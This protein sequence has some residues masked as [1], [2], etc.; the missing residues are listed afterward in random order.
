MCC[1]NCRH[2]DW[3]RDFCK[4]WKCKI[5]YRATYNCFSPRPVPEVNIET[6]LE[7]VKDGEQS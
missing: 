5:D 3:Y 1:D 4:K 7:V 6:N 2:Y